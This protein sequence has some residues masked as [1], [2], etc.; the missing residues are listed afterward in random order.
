MIETE[1]QRRWWFANHPEYSWSNRGARGR[2]EK[3]KSEDAINPK[4][5]DTYLTFRTILR[6]S[7]VIF[8]KP[9]KMARQ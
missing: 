2:P 4:D 1:E 6:V 8:R 3:E 5:V 7:R 9:K